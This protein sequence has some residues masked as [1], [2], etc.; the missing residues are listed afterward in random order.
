MNN[1]IIQ[2]QNVQKKFLSKHIEIPAIADVS[3]DVI[4]KEF[5]VIMG[6]SGCGKSTLLKLMAGLE[7]P[8]AGVLNI[9]G[10]DCC[11]AYPSD[12]KKRIGFMYQNE[13]LLP[14][15]TVEKNLRLPFEV[16]KT[17]NTHTP[18]RISDMLELVGLSEYSDVMPNELS[19]GM[20][21][22]V[23]IARALVCNPDIVL[24][25]QPFGA[26]DAITRKML[27]FD[28]LNIWKKTQKT[29]VMTT[30]NVDEALLCG[31]R[32]VFLTEAPARVQEIIEVD[33]PLAQR[34]EQMQFLPRYW[35]LRKLAQS[36]AKPKDIMKGSAM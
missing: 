11:T 33:I 2:I 28:F 32:I 18:R 14:W 3:F 17:L 35:E 19:G 26:L 9:C 5:I 30:N 12:M 21:Q 10:N 34:D 8:S 22:R 24:M 36:L 27:S 1:T 23:G 16:F 29:F 13:N 31:S 15:R 20:K 25:D 7:T 6:P 4:D